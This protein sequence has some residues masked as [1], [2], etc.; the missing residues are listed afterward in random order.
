ML[1]ATAN[2]PMKSFNFLPRQQSIK[3]RK[4]KVFQTNPRAYLPKGPI[5]PVAQSVPSMGSGDL[6]VGSNAS[7]PMPIITKCLA[8]R[9]SIG[10]F[11]HGPNFG[12]ACTV[13]GC[14]EHS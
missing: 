12:G 8:G 6:Q 2:T 7:M 9:Y 5:L 13:N 10:P 11:F 1:H 3:I 14:G 4:I